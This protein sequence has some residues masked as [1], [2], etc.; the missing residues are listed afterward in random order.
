MAEEKGVDLA[1][2]TAAVTDAARTRIAAAV[3]DGKL[4]QAQA[5]ADALTANLTDKITEEVRSR[6]GRRS[7]RYGDGGATGQSGPTPVHS[8]RSLSDKQ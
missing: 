1:T 8:R 6:P 5:Q 7:H 4:T 3:E 2:V